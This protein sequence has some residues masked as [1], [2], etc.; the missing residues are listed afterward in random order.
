MADKKWR[1]VTFA[2]SVNS[3]TIGSSSGDNVTSPASGWID[4]KDYPLSQC[5][6]VVISEGMSNLQQTYLYKELQE[7]GYGSRVALLPEISALNVAMYLNGTPI[8][9]EGN[10]MPYVKYEGSPAVLNYYTAQ[11]VNLGKVYTLSGTGY[12]AVK[13]YCGNGLLETGV[14][15]NEDSSMIGHY[16]YDVVALQPHYNVGIPSKWR[17][18]WL[19]QSHLDAGAYAAFQLINEDVVDDLYEYLPHEPEG[20]FEDNDG[21]DFDA[22]SDAIGIPGLPG[23]NV[24]QTG[25]VH[26]YELAGPEMQRF[27]QVLWD[28][29]LD[30]IGLMMKTF[31]DPMQSIINLSMCPVQVPYT[32]PNANIVIGNINWGETADC[33]G[34]AL[35]TPYKMIDFGTIYLNEFWG[36]FADYSPHTR[37][38]IFLPYCGVQQLAVDDVMNGGI[39]LRANC[40][41]FTGAI[42]YFLFSAQTNHRGHGHQSVLYT[43]SGNMKYNM[44]FAGSDYTR[45]IVSSV[46]NIVSTGASGIGSAAA[47]MV[48]GAIGAIA[49]L[50]NPLNWFQ[51]GHVDRGSGWGGIT[52]ALGHQYPYLILERP[53][54][55][56]ADNYP[57]T[58]GQPNEQTDYLSNYPGS[59]VK[60]RGCHIEIVTATSEELAELDKL[61]KEGV[62]V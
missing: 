13:A 31:Q 7:N 33:T 59:F 1:D 21:G 28:E 54:L 49:D 39:N 52:G 58:I 3:V 44:P 35:T 60:V 15:G 46:A 25:F 12:N 37:I 5:G 53:E 62:V 55:G 43:W 51:K 2:N 8:D 61:L 27:A 11:G 16:S 17:Y 9:A 47:G 50:G 45:Q 19:L 48:G 10:P 4:S 34:S 20:M 26:M 29:K 41:V 22:N 30:L 40:D 6:C 23:K 18:E 42:Q 38:S 14:Y 32:T 56:M 57:H 36:N 24:L